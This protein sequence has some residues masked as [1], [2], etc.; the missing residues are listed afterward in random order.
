MRSESDIGLTTAGASELTDDLDVGRLQAFL[1]LGDL[2]AHFL[3]I[4]QRFEAFSL[5]LGE[6]REQVIAAIFRRDEA[7]A[8][9]VVKPFDSASCHFEFLNL[10]SND[11]G[12]PMGDHGT[13]VRQGGNAQGRS[14]I[15]LTADDIRLANLRSGECM[16]LG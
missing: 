1:T 15:R 13:W 2:K 3:A 11:A 7:V 10:R 6:V 14:R 16:T 8:F 4:L 9:G 12:R 5:D